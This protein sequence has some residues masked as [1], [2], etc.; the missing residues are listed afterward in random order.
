L[1]TRFVFSDQAIFSKGGSP[2]R[3][4]YRDFY[5]QL[6]KTMRSMGE[7]E[8]KDL[9]TWWNEYVFLCYLTLLLILFA[10]R[11]IFSG[12]DDEEAEEE[13][14]PSSGSLAARMR[15]QAAAR[16][17]TRGGGLHVVAAGGSGDAPS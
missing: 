9:L 11:T 3:F 2:G 10:I 17:A 16:Q 1:Q 8:L 13:P 4:P 5:Y 14:S 7:E 6:I 12:D 15:A